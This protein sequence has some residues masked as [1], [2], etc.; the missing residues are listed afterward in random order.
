MTNQADALQDDGFV[1]QQSVAL[2]WSFGRKFIFLG[3]GEVRHLAFIH[4][5][6]LGETNNTINWLLLKLLIVTAGQS[7]AFPFLKYC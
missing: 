3:G 5:S 4:F 7:D 1:Q 6:F 2:S